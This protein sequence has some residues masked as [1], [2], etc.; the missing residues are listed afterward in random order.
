MKIE[1]NAK[2]LREATVGDLTGDRKCGFCGLC[3]R[4]ESVDLGEKLAWLSCPNYLIKRDKAGSEHSYY[5]VALNEIGYRPGDE[6]KTHRETRHA[7]H[8][9]TSSSDQAT[10]KPSLQTGVRR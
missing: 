2:I 3:L 8:V 1:K 9:Q 5:S 4:V 10:V 7:P 6:A